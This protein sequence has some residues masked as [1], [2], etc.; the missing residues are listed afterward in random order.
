MVPRCAECGNCRRFVAK[1]GQVFDLLIFDRS[2]DRIV[3][4][5]NYSGDGSGMYGDIRCFEC[6]SDRVHDKSVLLELLNKYGLR[7]FGVPAGIGSATALS[8][9]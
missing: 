7:E 3:P 9:G 4:V 2:N 6:G 5:F 1:R 8:G